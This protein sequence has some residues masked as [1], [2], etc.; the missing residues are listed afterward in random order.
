MKK[1]FIAGKHHGVT[2]TDIVSILTHP[3]TCVALKI[4]HHALVIQAG[5]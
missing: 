5:K 3:L 2:V 4:V 1:I